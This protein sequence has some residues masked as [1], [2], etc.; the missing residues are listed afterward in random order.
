MVF[1]KKIL[2]IFLVVFFHQL[3]IQGTRPLIPLL[4][5]DLGAGKIEIG[6]IAATFA[7]FPLFFAISAG[8]WIDK[9][10]IK[11]P[12]VL[13]SIGVTIALLIPYLFPVVLILYLSQVFAGFSQIFINISLQNA[14]RLNSPKDQRDRYYGWFSFFQSAGQFSGPLIAGVVADSAG[15]LFGFLICTI[16]ALPPILFGLFLSKKT[17][18][19]KIGTKE[20]EQ[21]EESSSEDSTI[22]LIQMIS[23]KGMHQA[24]LASMLVLASREVMMTYFPLYATEAGLSITAVGLILGIQGLAQM[25][26]RLLQGKIL[27]KFKRHYVLFISLF[28]AG[29]SI[30][31]LTLFNSLLILSII[32]VFIGLGIGLTQP[33]TMVSI[34]NLVSAT[35]TAQALGL[36]MAGNRLSQV[37]SPIAFGGVAQTFSVSFIFVI[38]GS[39][40]MLGSFYVSLYKK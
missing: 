34:V 1:I 31:I 6:I 9:W 3:T 27:S 7:V 4:A 12:I 37:I 5:D 18:E 35:H 19:L 25:F 38:G 36:R 23:I 17:L 2:L 11:W 14:I 22:T 32:A 20:K 16:I 30:V 13:G 24:M 8:K 29:L 33:L 15:I 10:G 26:I 39:L 28:T 21:N 40:L